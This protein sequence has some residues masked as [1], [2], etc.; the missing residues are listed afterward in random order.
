MPQSSQPT[1]P[2]AH[3]HH[4]PYPRQLNE[5]EEV[6]PADSDHRTAPSTPGHPDGAGSAIT[7]ATPPIPGP[8]SGP[9]AGGLLTPRCGRLLAG[10]RWSVVSASGSSGCGCRRTSKGRS[11]VGGFG[12]DRQWPVRIWA[13]TW[14]SPVGAAL[15]R[16][17]G[18][19]PVRGGGIPHGLRRVVVFGKPEFQVVTTVTPAVVAPRAH[20]PARFPAWPLTQVRYAQPNPGDLGGE[21]LTR[22]RSDVLQRGDCTLG[23]RMMP[24]LRRWVACELRVTARPAPFCLA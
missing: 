11:C 1:H 18:G 19:D 14:V 12:G 20:L 2:S 4:S 3:V 23:V 8:Q 5:A 24:N 6:F 9:D 17:Q 21:V 16:G 10:R 15:L 7:I 22:A 13:A